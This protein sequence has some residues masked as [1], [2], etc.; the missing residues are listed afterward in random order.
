L[1]GRKGAPRPRGKRE[2]TFRGPMRCGE[3]GALI[4]GEDKWKK[5][6]GGGVAEYTY[7]HCTKRKNPNC[8]QKGIEE[9][10]LEKQITEELEKLEIPAD[11]TQWAVARLKE[12]NSK[13]ITDREQMYGNQRREYD[14]CIRKIDTLVD[15]RAGLEIDEH[16]FRARKEILL[17]EK[18]RL[19]SFLKDTDKRVENW[20]E[21]AERG[22]NF[23]EQ[24]PFAFSKA[25]KE[26]K[27]A[28]KKEIFSA[29]GSNYI[30][31]AGKL[32]I[33][34]DDLL[35]PIEKMAEE[36][37]TLSAR[38]ELENQQGN[39][40]DIGEIYSKSPSLLAD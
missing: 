27:L 23:A 2:I 3:C 18:A 4:T 35:F 14:A 20:L 37:R 31:T 28:V 30:L 38:L 5:L 19:W 33:S 26:K 39:T 13:E 25:S 34:L 1:L 21:I 11:F 24:A 6:A 16:E 22:F 8:S 17:A 40:K 10:R 29:L 12:A 7:Y 36:A 15:M 32:T 9:K